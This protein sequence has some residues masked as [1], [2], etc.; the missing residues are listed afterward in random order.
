MLAVSLQIGWSKPVDLVDGGNAELRNGGPLAFAAREEDQ[1]VS[2]NQSLHNR[3]YVL[4]GVLG[5]NPTGLIIAARLEDY[6]LRS[7]RN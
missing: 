3:F 1:N 5:S 4:L 2:I 7:C 6:D